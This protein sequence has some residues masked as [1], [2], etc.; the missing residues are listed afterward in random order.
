LLALDKSRKNTASTVGTDLYLLLFY[1][2]FHLVSWIPYLRVEVFFRLFFPPV[3]FLDVQV[4]FRPRQALI[5]VSA[6]PTFPDCFNN[7]PVDEEYQTKTAKMT[8]FGPFFRA[9]GKVCVVCVV[10]CYDVRGT[11][12]NDDFD[13]PLDQAS[14]EKGRRQLEVIQTDASSPVYGDCW[15]RALQVRSF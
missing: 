1:Y 6:T 3:V 13:S 4:F 8:S 12:S 5:D 11:L 14:I 7:V 10:L 2:L 9:L 15:L